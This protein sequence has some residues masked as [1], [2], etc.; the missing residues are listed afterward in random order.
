[1]NESTTP[2]NG[3]RNLAEWVGTFDLHDQMTILIALVD[4]L[5]NARQDV[6]NRKV[7]HDIDRAEYDKRRLMYE[8]AVSLL[9]VE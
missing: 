9:F 4:G 7:S 8:K 6:I 2:D 3:L 1:M 5:E